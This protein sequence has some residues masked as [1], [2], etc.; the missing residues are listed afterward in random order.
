MLSAHSLFYRK[1]TTTYACNL[2]TSPSETGMTE[3]INVY[4]DG[5][6][7]LPIGNVTDSR[8]SSLRVRK[9]S[10]TKAI[11]YSLGNWAQF[12]SKNPPPTTGLASTVFNVVTDYYKTNIISGAFY[13]IKIEYSVY[14]YGQGLSP[15]VAIDGTTYTLTLP[16]FG[17]F[18]QYFRLSTGT[19]TITLYA[20]RGPKP[21]DDEPSFYSSVGYCVG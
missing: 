15:R 3:Y 2:Y 6:L 16:G 18:S 10:V 21:P 7:Y 4:Y 11:L 8:A 20:Y 1:N 17:T 9:G 13:N 19:H 5:T 14:D 12:G